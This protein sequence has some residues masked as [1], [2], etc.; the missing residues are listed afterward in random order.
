MA[1]NGRWATRRALVKA[2]AADDALSGMAID[3][4]H[5]GETQEREVIWLGATTGS[6]VVPV[7]TGPDTDAN[8]ITYDDDFKIPVHLVAGAPGQTLDEAEARLEVMY[9]ALERT[10]RTDPQLKKDWG[11]VDGLIHVLLGDVIGPESFHTVEGMASFCDVT[12]STR[13]RISGGAE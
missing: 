5:M 4:G 9:L 8:P 12:L 13:F 3:T 6:L 1:T 10:I 2:L 11:Q 7:F